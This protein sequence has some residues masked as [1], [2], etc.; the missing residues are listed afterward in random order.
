MFLICFSQFYMC[1]N[2]SSGAPVGVGGSRVEVHI[3]LI[4]TGASEYGVS[5][6]ASFAKYGHL[7]TR[8]ALHAR[9]CGSPKST[10]TFAF[11]PV[12]RAVGRV[13]SPAFG[14]IPFLHLSSETLFNTHDFSTRLARARHSSSRAIYCI[15]NTWHSPK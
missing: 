6:D 12:Q 11:A 1:L 8:T 4:S 13:R 9:L 3:A 7:A 10:R 14:R 2:W 5:I 15:T